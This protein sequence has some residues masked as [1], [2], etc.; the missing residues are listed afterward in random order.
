MTV[1]L[2][3][4]RFRFIWP[5]AERWLI[6]TLAVIQRPPYKVAYIPGDVL[7]ECYLDEARELCSETAQKSEADVLVMCDAD[8]YLS[9]ADTMTL[10][11]ETMEGDW[12]MLGA[13]YPCRGRGDP[14]W[15]H[16]PEGQ[17]PTHADL[18]E[19]QAAITT[20][21]PLRMRGFVGGSIFAVGVKHLKDI[22]Q[23]WWFR[24]VETWRQSPT[25]VPASAAMPPSLPR[26]QKLGE[27]VWFSRRALA[28]GK[29]IGVHMGLRSGEHYG[30]RVYKST[31]MLDKI[32]ELVKQ[33]LAH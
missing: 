14:G 7:S 4:P 12:A 22:P 30:A 2:A 28:A 5:A 17:E 19:M 23:P 10:I 33:G 32:A 16:P 3:I 13:P 24:G 31:T 6:E 15:H 20:G 27:D 29:K 9:G 11:N 1:L 25:V 8:Q 26:P 18:L 21:T